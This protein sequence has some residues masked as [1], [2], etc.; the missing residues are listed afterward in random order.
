MKRS[1]AC[2]QSVTE[3]GNPGDLSF[4]LWKGFLVFAS[5][6]IVKADI[7]FNLDEEAMDSRADSR[8]EQS[9]F[10]CKNN[11]K[12][13]ENLKNFNA[14]VQN[15]FKGA[16]HRNKVSIMMEFRYG[17]NL[18]VNHKFHFLT[19][20]KNVQNWDNEEQD[21][22]GLFDKTQWVYTGNATIKETKF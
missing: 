14:L 15:N 13:F 11:P 3:L 8:D 12:I 7:S 16:K 21:L 2:L 20:L 18:A 4:T 9:R 22:T 10:K 1:L 5:N 17:F 6:Q 19:N